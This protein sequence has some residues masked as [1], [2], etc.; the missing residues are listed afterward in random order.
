MPPPVFYLKTALQEKTEMALHRL[1]DGGRVPDQVPMQHRDRQGHP[2]TVITILT[3]RD[4]RSPSPPERSVRGS[5]PT[6]RHGVREPL[7]PAS[8][9]CGAE[10]RP[11]AP[12]HAAAQADGPDRGPRRIRRPPNRLI[13][14][15]AVDLSKCNEAGNRNRYRCRRRRHPHVR[16]DGGTSP[17]ASDIP[18]LLIIICG[19]G[20][21]SPSRA[22]ACRR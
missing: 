7:R 6:L 5:R 19:T 15:P 3:A 12:R 20:E 13:F 22:A 21:A 18:A 4:R 11:A 8:W 17:A 10:A 1:G 14:P 9:S 2:D 16:D